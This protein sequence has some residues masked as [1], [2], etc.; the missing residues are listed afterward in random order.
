[1]VCVYFVR[2]AIDHSNDMPINV[3]NDT[4]R[5]PRFSRR[6]H[7]KMGRDWSSLQ[8]YVEKS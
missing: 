6:R 4:E 2:V 5:F 8:R 1:M 3:N 7:E